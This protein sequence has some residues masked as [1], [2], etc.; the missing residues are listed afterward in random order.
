MSDIVLTFT[1]RPAEVSGT[2]MDAT[3]KPS[4][5]LSIMLFSTNKVT[6]T[7]R[8]RWLRSPVRAGVDG[9]FRFTNLLPGEYFLAAL[10]DFEQADIVKPDF[11]EQVAAAAMKIVVAEGEK[12]VQDIKIAGGG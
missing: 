7:T 1:D 5:A 10:S 9:K 4:S 3:G 2:L 8:S 6:W 11:L 12:K